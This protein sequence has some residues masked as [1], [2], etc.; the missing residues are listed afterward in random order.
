MSDVDPRSSSRY[1]R[2]TLSC[3]PDSSAALTTFLRDLG[4]LGVLEEQGTSAAA[5]LCAFF[6]ET[7]DRDRLTERVRAYVT[8]IV[9]RGARM[10]SKV[11]VSPLVADD[12][13]EAWPEYF[14]PVAVGR[15][16]LIAP[17]WLALGATDR[18]VI[19]IDAG[20]GFGTGHHGS[21]A[22]CLAKV[23]TIV[24]RERPGRAI[25]LGTGSGLLAI[26]AARLGVAHVFAVDNDPDAIGAAIANAARNGVSHRVRCVVGD[27]GAIDTEPAPLVMANL[28][29]AMHTRLAL[30]YARLV[31]AG[32][33]AVLGGILD[34]EANGVV[35]TMAGT[36]LVLRDQLTVD[37]WTTLVLA[38]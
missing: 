8:E 16:L 37:G 24:E 19:V 21:T 23:E 15:R 14:V 4:A 28:L 2:L 32:G 10:V 26:A 34:K 5:S 30:R 9:A 6:D 35:A 38:R 25:D 33:A 7:W 27:A 31:R 36:G 12:W 18:E 3:A 17:P 29:T 22:G 1:W 13:A 20:Q 11:R